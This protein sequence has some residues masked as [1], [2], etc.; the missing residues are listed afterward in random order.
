[1]WKARSAKINSQKN[2]EKINK[3]IKYLLK[4]TKIKSTKSR[5]KYSTLNNI[6]RK[7]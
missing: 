1:M 7:K 2:V 6:Q 3:F 4:S 5:K